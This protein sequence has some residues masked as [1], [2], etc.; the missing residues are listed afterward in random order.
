MASRRDILM[1]LSSLPVLSLVGCERDE[2]K[3]AAECSHEPLSDEDE[4]A[5]C[6]MVIVRHP[7]P[8]G[9]V[10]LRDG[11]LLAFCSVHD[12]LSWAWQ[13][14]SGPATETMYVHDLVHTGWESPAAEAW[15]DAEAAVY[16]VGHDRRG[17]MGHSPAPFSR[18]EEAEAFATEYGGRVRDFGELDWSSLRAGTSDQRRRPRP[19]R[20]EPHH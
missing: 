9:Q 16:V 17:A 10:C 8:K 2:T 19:E 15:M 4:C 7:G 1:M 11:T 18:R 13:P 3:A 5:M 12:L 6:G 20:G 14:E